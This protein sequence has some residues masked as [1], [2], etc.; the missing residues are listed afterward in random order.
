MNRYAL[1]RRERLPER[2][3]SPADLRLA[4]AVAS[5]VVV[6]EADDALLV[7]A[8]AGLDAAHMALSACFCSHG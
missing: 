6:E 4:R 2:P 3:S 1:A 7:L 8:R 5:Q